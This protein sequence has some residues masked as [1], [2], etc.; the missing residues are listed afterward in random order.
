MVAVAWLALAV[1]FGD[2]IAS[3]FFDYV[4][5]MHR[6]ATALLVGVFVG[7]WLTYLPGVVFRGVEQ[8]LI[9]ANAIALWIMGA[10]VLLRLGPV[11][12]RRRTEAAAA[13]MGPAADGEPGGGADDVAAD[14]EPG[15][16]ADDV[17][18]DG[19]REKSATSRLGAS[20]QWDWIVLGAIAALVIWLMTRTFQFAEGEIRVATDLWSDFGP[21]TAIAQSFAVGHN[22]PTEYPHYANAPILYHFMF[23]FGV[24]NLTFLGLDPVLANNVLS[25]GTMIAMLALVISL[26]R[27][28]F[29]SALAG[30]IGAVLFF[31]HGS[32]SFI[33]FLATFATPAAAIAGITGLD[34]F[35]ASGFPY[36]GEEWGI[37]T[38]VVYLNQRHLAS[39]I[40]ILLIAVLF[41]LSPR[42]M[43]ERSRVPSAPE[44]EGGPDQPAATRSLDQRVVGAFRETGIPGY[45]LCGLLLGLLPLWNSPLFVASAVVLGILFILSPN[46]WPM[47]A[48]AAVAGLVAL[49]QLAALRPADLSAAGQFPAFNWGYVVDDPTIVNVATYLAFSFGPKLILVAIAAL[50]GNAVQRRVLLAFSAL[51][52]VAFLLQ[53]SVEVLGNHKFLNTWLVV[54]NLFAA[55]A[56]VRFLQIATG[57]AAP[58]LARSG[59][60][61]V[62]VGL[63]V[64]IAAGGTIDLFRFNNEQL[65]GVRMAGDRLSDWVR[66]ETKTN[67]VFLTD[68]YVMHPIL[69]AGRR[70]YYG[71]PYYAW[72]AGYPVEAREALYRQMLGDE[73]PAKVLALLRQ[74]HIAY[75]AIDDGLRT[76]G[77]VEHVNEDVYRAHFEVAFDDTEH[78]YGGLVVYR[79]P[80]GGGSASGNGGPSA[81]GAPAGSTAPGPS[82]ATPSGPAVDMFTGGHGAGPGQLDGPRGIAVDPKGN[83]LV[84]DT[85]NNRIQRFAPDGTFLA[86]FGKRGVGPG[87]F[88]EPNGVA[89]DSRGHIFVA[90][91]AN[92]RLQEFDDR[93]QFVREWRGP[94]PGFYGPRDIAVGPD[95][96]IYILDQGR[97]RIVKQATDGTVS[98][99]GSLGTGDGQLRDPT[100]VAVVGDQVYVADATNSRVVVFTAAGALVR[101]WPVAE[102]QGVTYQYPDVVG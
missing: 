55:Y 8:P 28:L 89:V 22:F 60:R 71:W 72:S 48:M 79:V 19:D 73:D 44:P 94:E 49:P 96:A 34:H 85:Q 42:A 45:L 52:G 59:G 67:D 43:A 31:F 69:L 14:G 5:R 93:D 32:L 100:G 20:E 23:Y 11:W 1:L 47:L 51:I 33:P 4:G 91:T 88:N 21:T 97:G 86:S 38:Q 63:V 90:D 82:A 26:G 70:L 102:W 65:I 24:G 81:S 40:G 92:Q 76:R 27:R 18:A 41:V 56:L 62:A 80:Q 12:L 78:R 13:A 7:T 61:L 36:R 17:A 99:M 15:G 66:A 50:L 58:R 2:A 30:R 6:W 35:I 25:S 87:E 74:E 64:V 53:L 84:A 46:R 57:G 29:G 39:A 95:D 16:G 83:I 37:W 9:P 101:S 54:A 75:V 68:L 3:P 98:T 10:V 77:F